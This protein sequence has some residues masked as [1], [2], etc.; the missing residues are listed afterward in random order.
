VELAYLVTH[1]CLDPTE[2][3]AQTVAD[4]FAQIDLLDGVGFDMIWFPEHHFVRAYSSPSPLLG[5]V[6]AAHRVKHARVGTSVILAPLHHP[7]TLA[8]DIAYADHLT[9]GRLEV[10]FARGSSEYEVS[11]FQ[12]QSIEA[13]ERTREC[14]D[15]IGGL[16]SQANFAFHGKYWQFAQTTIVPRPLQQPMPR[17][18]IASRSPETVRYT[19]ER[20]LGMMLTVQQETVA[21]LQSQIGLV[22]AM[23]DD[24]EEYPRPPISVSRMLY[25]S[26][27]R[28]DTLRAMEYVA[29][30]RATNF[31]IH[32]D[33]ARIVGGHGEPGPLP[34]G[35]AY[36]PEE[37][38]DR[39][40]VGDPE[41]V[42]AKLNAIEA[43]GVDQFVVYMD[44]GQ[45]HE[46][47]RRSL[48]LF[49]TEVMPHFA[50]KAGNGQAGSADSTAASPSLIG[51]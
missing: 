49:A 27:D 16:L 18:W 5:A 3:P 10:G 35:Y 32:P 51:R 33:D 11:R 22:D 14:V 46:K 15:A 29:R 41:T 20:R 17:M 38:A 26:K 42:I 9:G 1:T 50:T 28:A 13:G 34:D 19:I 39:L 43:M 37:L 6:A 7:L 44:W 36:S 25:V 21:R 12:L 30:A 40:V 8:G 47:I 48:E 31:H 2:A 24:L 23:V 45:P 4:A